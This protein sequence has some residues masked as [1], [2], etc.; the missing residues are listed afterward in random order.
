MNFNSAACALLIIFFFFFYSVFGFWLLESTGKISNSG[1]FLFHY[2]KISGETVHDYR[3]LYSIIFSI[4]NSS[5]FVFYLAN[6]LLIT[7]L[8]PIV[9]FLIA[10]SAWAILIYFCGISF[11]HMT[12]FNA[13]YPAALM[14]LLFTSYLYL[15][16]H[17]RLNKFYL[18]FGLMFIGYFI[19]SYGAPL[20]F[21]I[22]I[23]ELLFEFFQF[24]EIDWNPKKPISSAPV[25]LAADIMKLDFNHILNLFFNLLPIQ[26]IYFG[27]KKLNVFEAFLCIASFI[28]TF[29]D[30]RAVIVA[31]ILLCIAASRE[32]K[33]R[34]RNLKIAFCLFLAM[35]LLFYL[36]SY[37]FE[38]W[39]IIVLN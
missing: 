12:L 17:F 36:V 33:G 11:V 6:L 31:E 38:T 16:E 29:L 32:I 7:I 28:T 2:A 20:F 5:P 8:I 18:I 19:H 15:R 23:T 25:V 3:P 21:A 24:Y 35:Q 30:I 9:L 37:C 1:D 27:I 4:F 10:R 14:M 13:T 22:L 26:I 34:N 39:K